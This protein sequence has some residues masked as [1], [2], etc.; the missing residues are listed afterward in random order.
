MFMYVYLVLL[1]YHYLLMH[2][3]VFL[4]SWTRVYLILDLFA[5]LPLLLVLTYVYSCLLMFITV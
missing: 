2:V 4:T 1:V 5:C 3:Y